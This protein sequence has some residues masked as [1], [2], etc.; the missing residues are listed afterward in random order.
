MTNVGVNPQN[1][2]SAVGQAQSFAATYNDSLG[3]GDFS[4][5][6]LNINVYPSNAGGGCYVVGYASNSLSLVNDAGTSWLS[7]ITAGTS[8]T[9]T[10]SKC[11]LYA[12]G[13]SVSVNGSQATLTVLVVPTAA[14]AGQPGLSLWA[15]GN[16]GESSPLQ[17]LGTWTIGSGSAPDLT[18][19]KTGAASFPAGG[20]GSYTLTVSNVG[21]ASTSGTV[22]VTDMLPSGLSFSAMSGSGWN[23][24]PP[25][26]TR[27]DSVGAGGSYPAI[28]VTVNVSSNASGTV[29]NTANVSGGGEPTPAITPPPSV[30]P[31]REAGAAILWPRS[32]ALR[33]A[34][35]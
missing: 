34:A 23:C 29:N 22:T 14:F 16:A 1:P 19:A 25:S 3:A 12:S 7:P 33:P 6:F 4:A 27:G 35:R 18:I 28:T 20:T 8:A 26:C 9:L 5:L 21:S 32:P 17:T 30:R 24:T 10:N 31:S 2:T 15:S 11:T 13:S